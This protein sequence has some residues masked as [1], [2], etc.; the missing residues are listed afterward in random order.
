[1]FAWTDRHVRPE[2]AGRAGDKRG[3]VAGT[4]EVADAS[5]GIELVNATVENSHG[6]PGAVEVVDD[7][8]A[9]EPSAAGN[10]RPHA[11]S[12]LRVAGGARAFALRR[13][14]YIRPG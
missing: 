7:G 1:V 4:M 2:V 10:E 8:T 6:V 9:H 5:G 11:L 14:N 12:L 3:V 13:Y